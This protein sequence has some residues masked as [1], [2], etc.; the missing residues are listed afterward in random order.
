MTQE[1]PVRSRTLARRFEA[2][3]C[4]SLRSRRQLRSFRS[5]ELLGEPLVTEATMK[6]GYKLDIL[7]RLF[8]K[9]MGGRPQAY[10]C[11]RTI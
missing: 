2:E 5:I 6:L 11:G 3:L 8:R 4:T 9:K 10:M 7:L 1:N